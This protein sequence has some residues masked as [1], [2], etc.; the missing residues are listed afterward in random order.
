MQVDDVVSRVQNLDFSLLRSQLGP[1]A[2][3][4]AWNDESEVFA[5]ISIEREK[6]SFFMIS[7][8]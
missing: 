4:S 1:V 8:D 2:V 6:I 5:V 3:V 7:Y